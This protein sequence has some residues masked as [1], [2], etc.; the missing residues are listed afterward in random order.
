V[1]AL[2]D[3]A[4]G[5]DPLHSLTSQYLSEVGRSDRA[6][7]KFGIYYVSSHSEYAPLCRFVERDVF[8]RAFSNDSATMDREYD[9][10]EDASFFVLVVDHQRLEPAGVLRA[11]RPSGAGHKTIRDLASV[12]ELSVSLDDV[13]QYHD[14]VSAD[15]LWDLATLAVRDQWT[16]TAIGSHVSAAL[17]HGIYR[18]ALMA[19][20]G[21]WVCALD[22]VVA[23]LIRA[24]EVPLR[25]V[26]GLPAVEYLGSPATAPYIVHLAEC[27][28]IARSAGALGRMLAFGDGLTKDFSLPPID[29]RGNAKVDPVALE[30][31]G[32]LVGTGVKGT[33]RTTAASEKPSRLPAQS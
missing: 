17:Y 12:P 19:G 13:S 1:A 32:E 24:A 26:C 14:G 29:L 15:D 6:E 9:P 30:P 3:L 28:A 2:I 8:R 33:S 11:I 16:Y 27:A 25:R 23:D 10:F 21:H 18:A 20:V 31:Q 22:E 4:D 7:K 5:F